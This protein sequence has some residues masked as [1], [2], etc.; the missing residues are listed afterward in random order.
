[1]RQDVLPKKRKSGFIG[2]ATQQKRPDLHMILLVTGVEAAEV[3][4]A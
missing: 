3:F 4:G 2:V 1:M